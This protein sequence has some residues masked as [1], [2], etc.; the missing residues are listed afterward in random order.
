MD[1]S[2]F[3]SFL[4]P[5]K[6]NLRLEVLA[7]RPDGYHEIRTI[8]CRL[9]LYDVLFLSPSNGEIELTSN[10]HEIP[11]DTSNL[12]YRAV[13]PLLKKTNISGGLKIHLEK[14]IPI[15]SGLGGGS[16]D[17]ASAMLGVKELY[18][19]KI[20]SS[21][22]IKL[23]AEIGADIP[24]FFSQNSVLATGIGDKLHPLKIA[25]PFW[26]LLITPHFPVSTA[27]AYSQFK[28]PLSPRNNSIAF[29]KKLNLLEKGE[30]ILYNDL[31]S[32]VIPRFPEIEEIKNILDELD[33][34]GSLM[35]GS[36]PTVFGIFFDERKAA[37]AEV[38]VRRDY[39]NRGWKISLAKA[40]I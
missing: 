39:G 33:A 34:W 2:V 32:V 8:M 29:S 18:G 15:A 19:L 31:E 12:V 28:W 13:L 6:I 35:S 30:T 37:R 22:L 17:A 11:L 26:A 1:K 14:H 21:E 27:W 36:G 7:K 20:S 4:A 38:K 3:K 10:S 16:S 24:F 9:G 5:A 25:P 23:G 40:L